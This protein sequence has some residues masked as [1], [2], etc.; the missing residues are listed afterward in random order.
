MAIYISR[1]SISAD[2]PEIVSHDIEIAEVESSDIDDTKS[3]TTDPDTDSDFMDDQDIQIGE[4]IVDVIECHAHFHLPCPCP[5][6]PR[7]LPEY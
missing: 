1:I 5:V 7:T 4:Y 3:D 2:D 6:L